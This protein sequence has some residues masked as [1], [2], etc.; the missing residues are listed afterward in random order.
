M[1]KKKGFLDALKDSLTANATK[2]DGMLADARHENAENV[3]K[4]ITN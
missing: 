4:A 3:A 2:K 1:D